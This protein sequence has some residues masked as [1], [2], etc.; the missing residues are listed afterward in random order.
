MKTQGLL[1]KLRLAVCVA[2]FALIIPPATV[3]QKPQII[4]K[5]QQPQPPAPAPVS[6]YPEPAHALTPE[7]IASFLDGLMP[8]TLERDDIAGAVVAVVKNG[9]VIFEKGYGYSDLAK[10][11][12]VSPQTTLF[13]PGSIS[14]LFTWTAVMQLVE[15]NKLDLDR[16]VNDYLDF[17]IPSRSGKPVTLRN[18]MTHTAGFEE[19]VKDL[20]VNDPK[21]RQPPDQWL[22]THV[23][24]RIFPPGELSAYSNYGAGLAGYIVQRTSGEP[25]EDYVEHHIFQ[26]LGMS[27]STFRQPLPENLKSFM[28]QGYE[29]ASDGVKQFE[30]VNPP[31]AGSLS[32]SADDLTHFML[33]HLQ[34][35]EYNG[36]RILQPGTVDAMHARQWGLVPEMNGMA[37]GFYE[38]S[39]NGHR[40]IGHGGDT[41][42]FHS[43]LHLVQDLN[44]GFFVSY[45]SA[46]RQQLSERTALWKE[47]LDRYYPYEVP[48]P[49]NPSKPDLRRFAGRY[50]T[51]RRSET[52]LLKVAWPFSEVKV[53]LGKDGVLVAD[54]FKGF[55][56]KPKKWKPIGSDVFRQEDGQDMI[57]FRP[58]AG[59]QVLVIDFPA[60]AFQRVV[61]YQNTSFIL[62]LTV[63]M[64]SVM[65]LTVIL[66]PVAALAR[67][68]YG[69]S[70]APGG[71]R[72][73]VRLLCLLDV[74]LFVAWIAVLSA[75]EENLSI[76]STASN[77]WIH[78]MQVFTLIGVIAT[79]LAVFYAIV[80]WFAPGLWWWARVLETL[81][82]IAAVIF[83]FLAL[84]YNLLH[85]GLHY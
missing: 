82:A 17:R 83:A 8:L 61:W 71:L 44:L 76:L 46:G 69:Q 66:W 16:D 43:D 32:A 5:K 45:N 54:A 12:P 13:R 84:N 52:S 56:G 85:F 3:A 31:P 70:P 30:V 72:V 20:I 60:I 14:K 2:L 35:G 42:Y 4:P 23:P 26:P 51:D 15:Q 50:L 18:L 79:I 68:H 36:A 38:E 29:K 58:V 34:H 81:I 41:I 55:N 33:A 59:R 22:K 65:V 21:L 57:A 7:D 53:S 25:F 39:R 62:A 64:L 19:V 75:A 49:A 78:V 67:K 24:A 73:I 28:S 77:G 37:L 80:A 11:T 10:K 9:K 63:F 40:I 47:F 6:T 74:A 27:H 48:Q 1:L